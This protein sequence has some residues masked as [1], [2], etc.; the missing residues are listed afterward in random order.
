MWAS[1]SLLPALA[2]ATSLSRSSTAGYLNYT[3]VT[4]YFLQD[5]ATTNATSLDY[6]S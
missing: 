5:V 2:A 3:T 1:L 4:G 6:V